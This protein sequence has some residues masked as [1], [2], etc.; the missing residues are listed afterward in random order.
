MR[1]WIGDLAERS[2]I[3]AS[4]P[5]DVSQILV[6][7]DFWSGLVTKE[8]SWMELLEAY[9]RDRATEVV[10]S[11]PLP[12]SERDA[13]LGFAK[14]LSIELSFVTDTAAK[15][16][17]LLEV[18]KRIFPRALEAA[19]ELVWRREL[20]AYMVQI[21]SD[22]VSLQEL[23]FW[24]GFLRSRKHEFAALAH[25]EWTRSQVLN[26]PQDDSRG[27]GPVA[28]LNPTLDVAGDQA[29]WRVDGEF[30]EKKISWS[31]AAVIDELRETPRVLLEQLSYE[32]SRK[33]LPFKDRPDFAEVING[34]TRD[35]LILRRELRESPLR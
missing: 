9:L 25:A 35:G 34:L 20:E 6:P 14:P 31:E 30:F 4:D 24:P 7:S 15:A 1:L 18:S 8:P 33:P 27:K 2:R 17:T 10:S 21:D 19:G 16:P 28:L 5:N 26:S 3:D 29:Y 22:F 13:W 23:R 12:A 11:M 32:V